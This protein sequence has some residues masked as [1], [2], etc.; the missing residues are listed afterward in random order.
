[1]RLAFD[2]ETNGLLDQLDR[3]HCVVAKDLDTGEVFSFDPNSLPHAQELLRSAEELVGHNILTFDLPALRKVYPD[4]QY[5]GRVTDTLVLSRLIHSDLQAE[6]YAK[7]YTIEQL[8]KRLHGSHSL[9]AWGMRLCNFKDDFDGGDWQSWSQEMQDYCVQDVEVTTALFNHLEVHKYSDRAI[10]LEHDLAAICDEIGNNGWTFDYIKAGQLYAELA[11]EREKLQQ[12]LQELFEPWEIHETIVPKVNNS[13]LGYVKGQ[14]FT[15]TTVVEFNPNSRRHIERCLVA[16][17]KW[18]PKEWTAAG[19]AKIDETVLASL[20]FPEARK[21]AKMFMIQKRIGQLAEGRSAWL[22]KYTDDDQKIRHSILSNGAVTGRATHRSPNLAQVPKVTAPYGRQCRELF[23]V[24]RGYQLV[25][26]DLSGLELRCLA[27]YLEDPE[28]TAQILDGDIHTFNQKAAGLPDRNSA[29]T[30]IYAALYGAGNKR[31]GEIV[32]GGAKEGA[33]LKRRF[34]E[35]VPSY[36]ILQTK[37]HEACERGYLIG[38]D[39]RRLPIRSQH[40]A[41]NTL[42]QAAGAVICKKWVSLIYHQLKQSHPTDAYIMAWVHDE[43]QI[44]VKKGYENDVGNITGRMAQEAGAALAIEIPIEADFSVG[45]TWA[46][47][48]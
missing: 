35:A 6:D 25:G 7:G 29:K 42:L 15:K 20:A 4:W 19:T 28:Y 40:A 26:A 47:T 38:L 37:V 2:I 27:H 18:K 34:E 22:H 10:D 33:E 46:D 16:K 14:P 12:E 48:H 43:V 23:T 41:L 45:D 36:R 8:P 11:G 13:K 32:G 1:M 21:L 17:Y 9:K 31:L 39:G 3:I 44:A 24:P 5:T 30:Y